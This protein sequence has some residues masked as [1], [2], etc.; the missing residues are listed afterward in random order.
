MSLYDRVVRHGILVTPSKIVQADIAI[1]D[2]RI[3][4][5]SPELTGTSKD[6]IDATGLHIFPGIIDAH[7][8]FNEPGRTEW[9]GFATGT[10]ALA[11]G[12][13]TAFFDMPLNAH[14]P[15]LD[16]ASFDLKLAAAQA[17]SLVDFAFW[18][19]I[20]PGNISHME[21]LAQCGVIGY[22]A[23][24]SNSG[25]DDF[26]AS[27]DLTLYEGMAEAARLRKIVAVHAENDAITSGLARRAIEQGRTGIRDY[28][29][30]RPVI[31]EL[32]AI[33]RAIL[34]ADET[35]CS[36][37]IVHVSTARGVLLVTEARARGIDVS[38]ETCP[39]YLVL[40][41]D[42]MEA[43]GAVAKCAPPLRSQQEQEALW[44]QVFAGN[45]PMITTDHSPAPAS[46]KNDANF[47]R[48]WGGISG[49]QSLLSLLLTEGYAY[50]S[51]PLTKIASLTAEYV[52][53]RFGLASHK[54]RLAP[55]MDADMVMVNLQDSHELQAT[56]LFYRHQHSP[57]IGKLLQG[58]IVQTLVRGTTVFREGTI[59]PKPVGQLL[60]P[61]PQ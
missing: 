61:S 12:G 32:E 10:K 50:R 42:D 55:G 39:H 35:A 48:V 51:L 38:C 43:L 54:G 36:L 22:K 53:Q 29:A 41:E 19:G 24:M 31:A 44:Q 52:A 11:A 28:L 6:E 3:V 2:G 16:A 60:R 25:I 18:G 8:H 15:T 49:C 40:T 23:F 30:S 13:T 14:P 47:F 26:L 20:V 33:E 46:M 27:D 59:T 45:V 57:Y 37:H 5:I 9:E 7:V 4:A 56:N 58:R 21:E 1:A 17:S 34:M